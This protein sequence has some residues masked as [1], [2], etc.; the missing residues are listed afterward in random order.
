MRARY[1]LVSLIVLAM[2]TLACSFGGGASST[3]DNANSSAAPT[4]TEVVPPLAPTET[5]PATS[6]NAATATATGESLTPS[7][8]ASATPTET[9]APTSPPPVTKAPPVSQGP[10]DFNVSLVGCRLDTSRQG[11][12]VLTFQFEPTGGNGV[13]SYFVNDTA[14][15]QVYDKPWTK[16]NQVNDGFRVTSGD[17]QSVNKKIQFLAKTFHCP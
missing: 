14:T 17:G 3:P 16:G 1:L 10:L 11:G 9:P 2:T 5:V 4:T 6:S 8:T 15:T 13:Y 7:P 12:I